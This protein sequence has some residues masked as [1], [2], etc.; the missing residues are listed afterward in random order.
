MF[1]LTLAPVVDG[2]DRLGYLPEG[3]D[4]SDDFVPLEGDNIVVGHEDLEGGAQAQNLQLAPKAALLAS[5]AVHD[6]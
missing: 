1:Q 3:V 6:A 4:E 5:H 2:L